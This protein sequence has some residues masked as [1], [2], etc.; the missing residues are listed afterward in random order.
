MTT[1]APFVALLVAF[2]NTPDDA[3]KKSAQ[4]LARKCSPCHGE[5]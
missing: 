2:Q 5:E 4:D 3:A 1:L